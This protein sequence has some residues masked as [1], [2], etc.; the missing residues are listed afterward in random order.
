MT[1][2]KVKRIQELSTEIAR[3]LY[4]EAEA[5]ELT[6]MIKIE[7]TVRDLTLE[8]VTPSIGIFLSKQSQILMQ[9]G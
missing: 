4:E 3:L 8:H 2:E 7:K 5:E 6:S 9:E 1:P